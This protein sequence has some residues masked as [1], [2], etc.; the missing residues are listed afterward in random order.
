MF[1]KIATP[2][3]RTKNL[4]VGGDNANLSAIEGMSNA[5][6]LSMLIKLIK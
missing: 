6:R 4:K 2:E 5:M 1:L 3:I